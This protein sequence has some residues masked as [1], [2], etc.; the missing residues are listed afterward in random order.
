MKRSIRFTP[1]AGHPSDDGM[2]KPLGDGISIFGIPIEFNPYNPHPA[3][4]RGFWWNRRIVVGPAWLKAD[5]RTQKA[6][7]LHEAKHCL[8]YHMERRTVGLALL[9]L[10]ALLLPLAVVIAMVLFGIGFVI[11][12]RFAENHELK[13]DAFAADQGYGVELLAWLKKHGPVEMPFYPDFETRCI[14]LDA[15]IKER[16]NAAS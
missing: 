10:P 13:A 12:S 2:L 8:D 4:A 3:D 9:A 7:L 5:P 6:I 1:T 11:V 15:R 16:E 14:E